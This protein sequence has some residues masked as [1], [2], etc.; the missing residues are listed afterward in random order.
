MTRF[1][2]HFSYVSDRHFLGRIACCAIMAMFLQQSAIGQTVPRLAVGQTVPRSLLFQPGVPIPGK[3]IPREKLVNIHPV[4]IF[5]LADNLVIKPFEMVPKPGDSQREPLAAGNTDRASDLPNIVGEHLITRDGKIQLGRFGDVHVAGLSIE[6][7]QEAIRA[8]LSPF[9]ENPQIEVDYKTGPI[10]YLIL[11]GPGFDEK[12]E[13]RL[14]APHNTVLDVLA[15]LEQTPELA[16]AKMWI[17]RWPIGDGSRVSIL[18]IDYEGI[19]VRGETDTNHQI[20]PGD[21]LYIEG[22][23]S[24]M[25]RLLT[26]VNR[27][28][29]Q[30]LK[31]L[32]QTCSILH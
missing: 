5:A 19:F 2:R 26:E 22:Q 12:V 7:T 32:S 11:S 20:L 14:I 24:V 15:T 27:P 31:F 28:F 30:T 9:L 21:R 8:H 10:Y 1:C 23:T 25:S 4:F 6:Q 3:Q 16:S 18:P 17:A 13:R 29:R